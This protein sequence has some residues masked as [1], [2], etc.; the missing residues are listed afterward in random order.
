M[1]TAVS[2]VLARCALQTASLM[3]RWVVLLATLPRTL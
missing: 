3:V 1:L 2:V